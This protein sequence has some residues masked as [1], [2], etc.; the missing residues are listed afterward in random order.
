M[1]FDSLAQPWAPTKTDRTQRIPKAAN[2]SWM[3]MHHPT[4][5]S[6]EYVK[7]GKKTKPVFVPKLSRF[8]MKAGVN[9]VGGTNDAPQTALARTQIRDNGNVIIDPSKHDYLRVYPAIGGTLTINKWTNPKNLGGKIFMVSDDDGFR[10]WRKSLVADGIIEVPNELVI[11]GIIQKQLDLIVMHNS[12]PHIP[13]AQKDATDAEQKLED[14]R[15]A[16]E[17]IK[18]D[19]K[20]YYE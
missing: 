11:Q 16:L 20:K 15:K 6:L 7:D 17:G 4:S 18:K 3:Y 13:Q 19:G 5:W 9:G 2:S 14:M 12:K 1:S 10:E 8:I